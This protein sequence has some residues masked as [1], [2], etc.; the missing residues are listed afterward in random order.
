METQVGKIISGHI[1]RLRADINHLPGTNP[2][3]KSGR[4]RGQLQEVE[5]TGKGGDGEGVVD[6][7]GEGEAQRQQTAALTSGRVGDMIKRQ[8]ELEKKAERLLEMMCSLDGSV[9]GVLSAW[10]QDE[11]DR[12]MR[13]VLHRSVS[14]PA[15]HSD[16]LLHINSDVTTSSD[17]SGEHHP[18]RH[19]L[20]HQPSRHRHRLHYHQSS[21]QVPRGAKAASNSVEAST[22]RQ[23][24]ATA[25]EAAGPEGANS[26]AASK[27]RPSK[28][29][30]RRTSAQAVSNSASE[31]SAS[32]RQVRRLPAATCSELI[33]KPPTLNGKSCRYLGRPRTR[34]LLSLVLRA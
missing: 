10:Q 29:T 25:S 24:V 9:Q 22:P 18:S 13:D 26:F 4:L 27:A 2:T 34:L 17:D 14:S 28:G 11:Q 20:H 33:P 5:Q 21:S 6:G 16:P 31:V 19:S 7:D 15:A 12:R 23:H 3:N 8:G 30:E 1:D 32:W